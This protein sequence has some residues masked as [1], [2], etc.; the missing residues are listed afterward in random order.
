MSRKKK[1]SKQVEVAVQKD[2]LR[3]LSKARRP[4]QAIQELIW[5]SLDADATLVEVVIDK[6]LWGGVQRIAVVDN[7]EGILPDKAFA[8][9]ERLGGSWKQD[10]DITAKGRRLHGKEGKGRFAAFSLGADVSWRSIAVDEEGNHF[11][12][13]VESTDEKIDRFVINGVPLHGNQKPCG[14][15][16]TIDRIPESVHGLIG[17]DAN[18]AMHDKF[19]LYLLK[20]PQVKIIY[21]G[22]TLDPQAAIAAMSEEKIEVEVD[23]ETHTAQVDIVE[24][25]RKGPRGV[26]L[27]DRHGFALQDAPLGVSTYNRRFTAHVKSEALERLH[28]SGG[29]SV[30]DLHPL[31]RALLH[32]AR[33]ALI[34]FHDQTS[35]RAVDER[36]QTWRSEGVYP[37]TEPAKGKRE[38][39][40]HRAFVIF[41]SEAEERAPELR[42]PKTKSKRL[43]FHLLRDAIERGPS[44]AHALFSEA[45]ELSGPQQADLGELLETPAE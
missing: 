24:W 23:G 8:A 9:F 27:C 17:E 10:A 35:R 12:C 39:A 30:G 42:R 18:T 33:E 6:N 34:D 3:K 2:H 36:I 7:G 11:S 45:F 5:N 43:L 13:R 40:A 41:A 38:A 26:Y 31:V 1:I 20:Y 16:V 22:E 44:H 25:K 4:L 15:T 32:A 19:S 14:T 28:T 29:L 37:F 21:N